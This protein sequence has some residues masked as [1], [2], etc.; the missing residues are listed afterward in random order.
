MKRPKLKSERYMTYHVM[1]EI[2]IRARCSKDA[3]EQALVIQ[4]DPSSGAVVF[5]VISE[6]GHRRR[7]DLWEE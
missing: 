7:V 2:D 4:R 1:W 3:A 5:D 6:K